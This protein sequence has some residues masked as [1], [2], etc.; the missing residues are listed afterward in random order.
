MKTQKSGLKRM[1]VCDYGGQGSQ[2]A[3]EPMSGSGFI[4]GLNLYR[5]WVFRGM[6]TEERYNLLT[7]FLCK[8]LRSLAASRFQAQHRVYET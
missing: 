5:L 8:F 1:R 2:R 7:Y 6:I 3:V 4:N